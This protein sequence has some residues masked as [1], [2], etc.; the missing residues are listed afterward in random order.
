MDPMKPNRAPIFRVLQLGTVRMFRL[1]CK[2]AFISFNTNGDLLTDSLYDELVNA[3]LD[4]LEDIWNA[5][6]FRS[7]RN[8]LQRNRLGLPLCE[9]CTHNGGASPRNY[10]RKRTLADALDW[11]GQACGNLVARF[12]PPSA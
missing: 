7:V 3:G 10:P 9:V 2:R 1:S 5:N 8:R 6:P 11:A 12:R 4:R